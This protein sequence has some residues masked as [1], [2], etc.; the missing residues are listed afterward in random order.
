MKAAIL[1]PAYKP[2]RSFVD[3]SKKLVERGHFVIAVDDGGGEQFA[4]IFK[5]VESFGVLVLRHEV[6]YGKGKA[7]RT[8]FT[9]ITENLPD[10]EA[11]VTADCDGQHKIKDIENILQIMEEDKNLFVIGGRFQDKSVKVPIKSQIGNGL[12]RVIFRV[13]TGLKVID[14]QTGLR[15]I[16]KS[17]FPEMLTIKGDRYEYEM[18]MLLK[19]TEWD[20]PYKEVPIETIYENNNKGS[21]YNPLKDS[22]RIF[23]QI[24]KFA[25]SSVLS[26]LVDY[27]LFILLG[28]FV[29]SKFDVTLASLFGLS[30][31]FLYTVLYNFSLAY[32]CARVVS[33]ILN[34]ELNRK[35]VFKK[36]S[37][38]SG[39][40]YF[41][42]AF[43]VMLIGSFGTGFLVHKLSVAPF[44]CKLIIDL[45][46]Y[47]ANYFI[48]RSWVFKK[49]RNNG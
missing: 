28:A 38:T 32:I 46:L 42:L 21:H 41:V 20:V 48:Q 23:V 19:L 25:A 18:N 16:P 44:V 37:K 14:T 7:L 22:A 40:K 27:A 31:G 24:L 39:I 10:I 49:S 45:P 11:V 33:S 15:G 6:N 1:I 34:Y 13:A 3:F 4:D 12:T 47:V 36:G 35:V 43:V 9:Y 26:F 2:E 8:G 5:E 29:F 17:L 30:E